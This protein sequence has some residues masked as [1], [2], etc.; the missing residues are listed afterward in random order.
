MIFIPEKEKC[1]IWNET[2]DGIYIVYFV[3]GNDNRE[4]PIE[5]LWSKTPKMNEMNYDPFYLSVIEC[6]RDKVLNCHSCSAKP[7]LRYNKIIN[8]WF[9]NCPSSALCTKNDDQDEINSNLIKGN[10]TEERGY[11][12]S[13]IEAIL[14]W[15][16]NCAKDYENIA[17]E[18]LKE[19]KN[20][21]IKLVSSII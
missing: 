4:L 7:Q 19:Y 16:E 12:D 5:F 3:D 2:E 21:K 9:C 10:L 17:K 13:P 8:K 1:T 11:C 15:N 14:K 20:Y 6:M 18:N